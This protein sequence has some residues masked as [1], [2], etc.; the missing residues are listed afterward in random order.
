M[1]SNANAKTTDKSSAVLNNPTH[2]DAQKVSMARDV[3]TAAAKNPGFAQAPNLQAAMKEWTDVAASL[4]SNGS[5]ALQLRTQLRSLEAKQH[6]FRRQWRSAKKQVLGTADV[7]CAGS[8]D[9]LKAYGF[10][11]RTR[12]TVAPI[13][14]PDSISAVAGK[15]PGEAVVSW[16]RGS[17]KHGFVV[18]SAADVANAATY[19][20]VIPTP[21]AK[22]VFS[23]GTPAAVMSFRVA[24]IDPSSPTGHTAWSAWVAGSLR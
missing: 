21:K 16:A 4:E 18:Q 12:T 14:T 23:G 20:A 6:A 3:A 24:A 17:A 15:A 1:A 10:Q 19:S 13:S 11:V 2:T 7:L 8:G 22:L 5:E 9:E